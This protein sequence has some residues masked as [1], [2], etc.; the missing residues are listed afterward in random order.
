MVNRPADPQAIYDY[1]SNHAPVGKRSDGRIRVFAYLTDDQWVKVK[2]EA[3]SHG[4]SISRT[5]R[6]L[7]DAS[8]D[9]IE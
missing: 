9:G 4:W 8:I 2:A 3:E 5:I 7:I 6:H 1:K